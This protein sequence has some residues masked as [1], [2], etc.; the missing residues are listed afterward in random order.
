[1]AVRDGR[2]VVLRNAGDDGDHDHMLLMLML[3]NLVMRIVSMRVTLHCAVLLWS[4]RSVRSRRCCCQRF[5]VTS[6]KVIVILAATR[7]II[8]RARS[9][10]SDGRADTFTSVTSCSP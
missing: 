1:M 4:R 5:G 6:K 7:A 3:A 10:H 2:L 8:K 9:D